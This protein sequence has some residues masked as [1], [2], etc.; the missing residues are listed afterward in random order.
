MT[1]FVLPALL[2]RGFAIR[3]VTPLGSRVAAAAA[4]GAA[5]SRLR[6]SLRSALALAALALAVLYQHRDSLWNRELSA[7]SPISAE[8]QN[9]DAKLRGDLGAADVRDL[10]I[11]S[12]PTSNRC[13]AAPNM[14]PARSSRWWTPM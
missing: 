12:G 13:C 11:V 9:Y 3:D 5:A 7:L 4:T 14:R 10:V 8:E 1:R 2:P 6:S